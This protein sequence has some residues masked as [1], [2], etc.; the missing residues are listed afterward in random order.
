MANMYFPKPSRFEVFA[1]MYF[2]EQKKRHHDNS[3]WQTY[4]QFYESLGGRDQV[5]EVFSAFGQVSA[6]VQKEICGFT[7]ADITAFRERDDAGK[8]YA[9]IIFQ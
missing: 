3:H 4:S 7:D 2:R 1:M 9:E 6:E 5:Y 8:V